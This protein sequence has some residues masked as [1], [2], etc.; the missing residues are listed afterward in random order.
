MACVETANPLSWAWNEH[1]R[2]LGPRARALHWECIKRGSEWVPKQEHQEKD[3]EIEGAKGKTGEEAA[4]KDQS[5]AT[6]KTTTKYAPSPQFAF[7]RG[8]KATQG[9]I[10]QDYYAYCKERRF[11]EDEGCESPLGL[12]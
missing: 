12:R 5:K 2:H 7:E 10:C 11:L 8:M 1:P 3:G 9:E 6:E 4:K